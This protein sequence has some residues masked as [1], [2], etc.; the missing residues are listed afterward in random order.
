MIAKLLDIKRNTYWAVV[1]AHLL[2]VNLSSFNLRLQLGRHQHV[3]NTPADIPGPGICPMCPPGV[4]AITFSK[5]PE[6]VDKSV[7]N[8]VLETSSF[9]VSETPLADIL[10]WPG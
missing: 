6:G 9:F 1:G 3:I 4:M 10:F 2:R 5:H 8:K 7:I